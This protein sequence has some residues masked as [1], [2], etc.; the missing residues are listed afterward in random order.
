MKQPVKTLILGG[1]G[2][3]GTNLARMLCKNPQY[4]V[5]SFDRVDAVAKQEGISYI[6]GDFFNDD[7]LKSLVDEYDILYHA[8]STLTPGN[9][10]TNY[11]N[12]YEKDFI[13]SVK[14]CDLVQKAGKKLIFLSSGGTV[15]GKHEIMPV[16]EMD[17]CQPI[18][19]YGTV[20]RCIESVMQAFHEQNNARMI[21]ARISN[22]YGPEQD[23]RKGVGVIDA[24][25]KNAIHKTPM[26]VWGD[27]EVI[28]DYIYIDDVCAMLVTLAE[29]EGEHAIFNL[30]SGEGHSV[31]DII[32]F[33]NIIYPDLEVQYTPGRP[34]DLKEIVLDNSRICSIYH[35]PMVSL[36]EGIHRYINYILEGDQM[37]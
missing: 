4:S 31:N 29:Y 12:G 23:F 13:Q 16:S 17:Y 14:L 32:R 33:V 37:A 5:T 36:Q 15:Y 3:I 8:I 19:H 2:F 35:Q 26:T 18:N 20:K 1:N 7:Q 30:S 6:S 27:G 25:I 10:N 24:V 28:R 34:V 11:M 21:V 9:S 22:P